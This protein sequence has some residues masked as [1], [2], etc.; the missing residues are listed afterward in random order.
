MVTI[1]DGGM[2]GELIRREVTPR[3]ELWS[4]QA[5]LDVPET[6]LAV[7]K[8]YIASGASIIITNS[9][10][11]IP[12]YLGKMGMAD[13]FEELT[14]LAAKLARQAADEADN[15]VLVAGSMPPLDESYRPGKP[16]RQT[17]LAAYAGRLPLQGGARIHQRHDRR[18][19]APPAPSGLRSA[20]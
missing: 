15:G 2:G 19:D 20:A 4:A 13:R 8:D 9:Y 14:I 11:T 16:V 5:L 6:V 1:L 12:S 10:S 18:E 7:H 17:G 3:N